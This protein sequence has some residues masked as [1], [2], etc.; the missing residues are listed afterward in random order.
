MQTDLPRVLIVGVGSLGGTIAGSL[1]A[2]SSELIDQLVPLTSNQDIIQAT[3]ASGFT[4]RGSGEA[5][6][7]A[8]AAVDTIPEDSGPFDWIILATQ[9]PQVEAAARSVVEHL[10]P[11]GMMI[12]LQNGLCENRVAQIVGRD[13]VVGAVVGW[14]ASTPAPGVFER[15]S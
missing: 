2:F 6:T 8:G 14:G 12:C 4:L 10:A 5:I 15:T 9:P 3:T 11:N 13:R 7:A 1:L